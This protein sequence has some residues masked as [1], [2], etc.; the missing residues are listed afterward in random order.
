MAYRGKGFY[1]E[2]LPLRALASFPSWDKMAFAVAKD[3]KIKSLF[4]IAERKIPLRISTRSSG[5]DNTTSY[6]V[7]KILA[8]YGL[9]FAQNQELGRKRAGSSPAYLSRAFGWHKNGQ[10]Q[11][12]IRRRTAQ[13]ARRRTQSWIRSLATRAADRETIVSPG[14]PGIRHPICKIHDSSKRTLTRL[15]SAAGR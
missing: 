8:L 6:T 5:V 9:S 10:G 15:I 1:K 4:E 12:R 3:L 14:L 13:L 7:T 11:C 2:K